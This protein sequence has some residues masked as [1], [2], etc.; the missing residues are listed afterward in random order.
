MIFNPEPAHLSSIIMIHT[1]NALIDLAYY[2]FIKNE[3]FKTAQTTFLLD[4]HNTKQ[5][6]VNY[7]ENQSSLVASYVG[8]ETKHL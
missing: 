7:H 3:I 5:D 2:N 4:V 8:G 6:W 1:P